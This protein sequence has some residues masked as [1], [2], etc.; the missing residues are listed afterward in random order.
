MTPF[1]SLSLS[2]SQPLCSYQD[3]SW[4]PEFL[5]AGGETG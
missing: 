4:V 2:E 3:M 1:P 5:R